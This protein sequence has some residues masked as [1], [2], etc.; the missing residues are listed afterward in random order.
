MVSCT[1]VA[2][3]LF[4]APTRAQCVDFQL[5]PPDFRMRGRTEDQKL[6]GAVSFMTRILFLILCLGFVAACDSGGGDVL[7]APTTGD[8]TGTDADGDGT[9]DE[10]P[11]TSDRGTPELPPG[12]TNPTPNNQIVRREARDDEDGGGFATNIQ[13][14]NDQGQDE[15][16]VDNIAFD[17]DNVYTRGDPVTGVAQLGSFAVYEGAE[18]TEDPVTGTTL[19]TF[20]YRAIY[21]RSTNGETEFAI[22]RSGSYV[23]FGFGGFVYQRNGFDDDGNAVRLVLPEEGDARYLGDYAGIRVFRG[24]GGLEYVEGDA[25]I[26][27]DFK[28]FNDGN[29]GVALFVNNRRLYDIN[30]TEITRAYLDALGRGDAAGDDSTTRSLIPE[31]DAE[32]NPVLPAIRPVISPDDADAN[33]EIAGEVFEIAQFDNGD[34]IESG[35]GTYFAI[36]SGEDAGEI[37]GVLVMTG[38]DPRF[39]NE[40]TYQETGGFIVYRQ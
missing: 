40:V 4:F 30:G 22:V 14:L 7:R 38:D 3:L 17:G 24:R 6:A 11:I 26:F 5:T 20:T 18:T 29:R 8:G 13:Y 12:T 33:G 19:R 28:D 37:V 23:D 9:P 1:E 36:V 15:F 10:T 32:G 2:V 31:M 25:E 34:T 39:D 35:E 16:F 21:G 27:V